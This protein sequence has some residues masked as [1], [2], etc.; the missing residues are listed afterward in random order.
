MYALW[1]DAQWNSELV[2]SGIRI[3]ELRGA[4]ALTEAARRATG[5]G[6]EA[7]VRGEERESK[8]KKKKKG[9]SGVGVGVDIFR[10]ERLEARRRRGIMEERGA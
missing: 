8:E 6:G 4:F 2:A 3:T 10:D 1:Q 7:L 5:F 9:W